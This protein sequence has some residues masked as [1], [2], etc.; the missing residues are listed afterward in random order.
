MFAAGRRRNLPCPCNAVSRNLVG[1][2]LGHKAGSTLRHLHSVSRNTIALNCGDGMRDIS[3]ISSKLSRYHFSTRCR[4]KG[5]TN[6]LSFCFRGRNLLCNTAGISGRHNTKLTAFDRL[7]NHTGNSFF[8]A[9]FGHLIAA[10]NKSLS[11]SAIGHT[12][13]IVYL[14]SRECGYNLRHTLCTRY[15]AFADRRTV[16]RCLDPR[17]F[18]S[19]NCFTTCRIGRICVNPVCTG[20]CIHSAKDGCIIEG[21]SA[22]TA[23]HLIPLTAIRSSDNAVGSIRLFKLRSTVHIHICLLAIG[24]RC[25]GTDMAAGDLSALHLEALHVRHVVAEAPIC[26]VAG[27]HTGC[28][29]RSASNRSN[30]IT[31]ERCT[32]S[33]SDTTKG[34]GNK[35]CTAAKSHPGTTV[36]NGITHI[37][38][39]A[40]FGS[41][42]CC[43]ATC[44]STGSG[45]RTSASAEYTSC[46]SCST[47][48]SCKDSGCH[49]QFHTHTG[50]GL[51][52]IQA[53]G[54][55][56]AVKP[57]RTL[58]V[59]Q[60]TEHPKED[61]S[62][63]G[64]QRATIGNELSHRRRKAT[65]EPDIHNQEQQLGANHS[66]PGSEDGIR[67]FGSAH[68]KG[69]RRSITENSHH[70]IPFHGFEQEFE[71]IPSQSDLQDE[72]QN[73]ANHTGN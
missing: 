69:K 58:K 5:S 46:T 63:S 22:F 52:Y 57:L 18:C 72:N 54:S 70:D 31:I 27:N 26:N 64:C 55:Q 39:G 48:C 9:S 15:N 4:N 6:S 34:T 49:K 53:N 35:A 21:A 28:I 16:C 38:I 17:R 43:K 23:C 66:A 61:A 12:G 40:E 56:I 44:C 10:R 47:T 36:Y 37:G 50:T 14:I 59:S 45:C 42:T 3:G 33:G 8:C 11:M 62:L 7:S 32:V 1:Y 73:K 24:S 60:C 20:L 65:Q 25:C 41:K 30:G 68:G 19:M 29:G 2:K 13:N 71:V 51:C 67:G